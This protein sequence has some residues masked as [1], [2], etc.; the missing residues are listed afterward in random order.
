MIPG[1][2][3]WKPDPSDTDTAEQKA[4]KQAWNCF[5]H[6]GKVE[7]Y[8]HYAQVKHRENAGDCAAGVHDAGK[9]SG[10]NH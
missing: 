8:I 5:Y 9:N 2:Y 10:F 6:T 4:E 3:T 1:E 7:D